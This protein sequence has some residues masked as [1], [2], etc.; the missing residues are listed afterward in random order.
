[1]TED[2]PMSMHLRSIGEPEVQRMLGWL[3]SKCSGKSPTRGADLAY[4]LVALEAGVPLVTLD[5][6]LRSFSEFG[7]DVYFPGEISN[8]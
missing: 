1:M 3:T 6:G 4:L 5:T 7:A 8:L 2:K